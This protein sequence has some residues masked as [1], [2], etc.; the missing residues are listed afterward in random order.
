MRPPSGNDRAG[1]RTPAIILY[2]GGCDFCV[3]Q[4]RKLARC[5]AG[6]LVMRSFREPGVL[7]Q[8][9]GLTR[10]QCMKEI[11]LVVPGGPVYGGAEA[12]VR[13]IHLGHPV[14][15]APLLGYYLPLLR[16]IADRCYARVARNRYRLPLRRPDGCATGVCERHAPPGGV[17][18]TAPP[19]AAMHADGGT[20][21]RNSDN[22]LN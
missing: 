10:E 15:G 18:A 14:L 1:H 11:K 2:D 12:I 19:R 16:W 3:S 7:E 9:P 8:F 6:K 4:A 22:K 13:S 5:G 20:P 17:R 21:A